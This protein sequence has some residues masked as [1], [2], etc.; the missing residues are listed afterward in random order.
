MFYLLYNFLLAI[1]IFLKGKC[2]ILEGI[3]TMMEGMKDN[4]LSTPMVEA[5]ACCAAQASTSTTEL[6]AAYQENKRLK[7]S[8]V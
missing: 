4:A 2:L 1:P 8:L 6:E 3:L 5:L 7:G